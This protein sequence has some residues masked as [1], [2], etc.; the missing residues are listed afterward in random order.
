MLIVCK[1][2]GGLCPSIIQL[3]LPRPWGIRL[4]LKLGPKLSIPVDGKLKI[5]ENMKEATQA[6]LPHCLALN[7]YDSL[8]SRQQQ[9]QQ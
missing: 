3:H 7:C 6:A 1:G 5:L 8:D 4:S 2:G 9:Q